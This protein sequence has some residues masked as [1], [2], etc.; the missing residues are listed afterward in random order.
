MKDETENNPL[1][2]DGEDSCNVGE[3]SKPFRAYLEETPIVLPLFHASHTLDGDQDWSPPTEPSHLLCPRP[4]DFPLSEILDTTWRDSDGRPTEGDDRLG[5]LSSGRSLSVS[6][7]DVTVCGRQGEDATDCAED[8]SLT[9]TPSLD[10]LPYID[11]IILNAASPVLGAK[12]LKARPKSLANALGSIPV[13]L[14]N[15]SRLGSVSSLASRS[16]LQDVVEVCSLPRDAEAHQGRNIGTTRLRRS[17]PAT[18]DHR[19]RVLKPSVSLDGDWKDVENPT[20]MVSVT[21]CLDGKDSAGRD[22]ICVSGVVYIRV[23][24]SCLCPKRR[25]KG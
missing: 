11:D 9:P 14:T 15:K 1:E 18:G 21:C 13:W 16:S 7:G 6:F 2:N 4:C 24:F 8:A 20:L 25:C 3:H 23:F 12:S 22:K 17:R 10:D 19:P 5:S